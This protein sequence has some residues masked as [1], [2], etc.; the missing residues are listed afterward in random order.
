MT[1]RERWLAV[2]AGKPTDRIPVDLTATP[3][4]MTRLLKELDCADERKLWRTLHVDGRI[5]V[6]PSITMLSIY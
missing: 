3:E 4:V 1:P 2:L 6:A 5:E